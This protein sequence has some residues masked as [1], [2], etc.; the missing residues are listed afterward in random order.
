MCNLRR[1]VC[2]ILNSRIPI[3][4]L[5]GAYTS[6]T[7]ITIAHLLKFTYLVTV[8]TIL[9]NSNYYYYYR[10]SLDQ[11]TNFRVTTWVVLI[12]ELTVPWFADTHT[13]LIQRDLL[14]RRGWDKVCR[15]GQQGHWKNS[16]RRETGQTIQHCADRDA[17]TA[18]LYVGF[19]F[20]GRGVS[21]LCWA[22]AAAWGIPQASL[23][24]SCILPRL[25]QTQFQ[26][27]CTYMYLHSS[28]FH[29]KCQWFIL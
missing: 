4:V 8:P 27:Y 6:C 14:W 9:A 25:L 3:I 29:A 7:I 28:L 15:R 12:F 23:Q 18:M 21:W 26:Y 22:G 2:S 11:K 17:F 19:M 10:I 5:L 13:W 16:Y 1:L 20:Y 24:V